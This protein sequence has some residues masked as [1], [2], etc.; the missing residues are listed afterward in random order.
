VRPSTCRDAQVTDP[1]FRFAPARSE[2][3]HEAG[4][5]GGHAG[6]SRTGVGLCN[7]GAA[8][9]QVEGAPRGPSRSGSVSRILSRATIHLCDRPG[10]RRATCKRSGL[11]LHQVG[12][13]W[14]PRHRDAGALL[15]HH[16][17]L[18]GPRSRTSAALGGVFSVA[19]SRGFP[20][21][22]VTDHL[23]LRCPDFPRGP[24][25]PRGCSIRQVKVA[26]C[27]GTVIRPPR[28]RP[29]SR[30]HWT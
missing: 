12:F 19:L 8:T 18:A 16:F 7:W 11:V 10:P 22:G 4:R 2:R 26:G 24:F 9:S 3:R 29:E 30:T 27:E 14:P 25:D 15:P 17:N 5:I 20:R 21:V 6:T 28:S 1:P 23:A 13:T